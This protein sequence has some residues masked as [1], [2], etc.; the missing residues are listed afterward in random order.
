MGPRGAIFSATSITW[1]GWPQ[2]Q[3]G[4]AVQASPVGLPFDVPGYLGGV[5]VR[6][7]GTGAQGS[8]HKND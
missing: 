7:V 8:C 4:G 6:G 2:R 5:G 3:K 1:V